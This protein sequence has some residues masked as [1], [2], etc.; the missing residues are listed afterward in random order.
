MS[1]KCGKSRIPGTYWRWLNC[2][3]GN[4]CLSIL[5][6]IPALNNVGG[7]PRGVSSVLSRIFVVVEFLRMYRL[8]GFSMIFVLSAQSLVIHRPSACRILS[9]TRPSRMSWSLQGFRLFRL[10]ASCVW[11]LHY[12]G[13][14]QTDFSNVRPWTRYRLW[15]VW[16]FIVCLPCCPA[17]LHKHNFT[18]TLQSYFRDIHAVFLVTLR[19]WKVIYYVCLSCPA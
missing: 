10:T 14:Y 12:V 4:W 18:G 3:L 5:T 6:A 7:R 9:S 17:A 19:C 2:G 11:T 1:Y 16:K 15:T 13:K 8:V